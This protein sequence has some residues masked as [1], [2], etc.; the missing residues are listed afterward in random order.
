MLLSSCDKDP[1]PIIVTYQ[2]SHRADTTF[3][4]QYKDSLQ[5]EMDTFCVQNNSRLFNEIRDSL[6][7]DEIAKIEKLMNE[8]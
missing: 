6:L 7:R 5:A 1:K 3:Q 8:K 2:L 4:K